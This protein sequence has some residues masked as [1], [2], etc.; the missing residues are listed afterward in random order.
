MLFQLEQAIAMLGDSGQQ[1]ATF[2]MCETLG[3]GRRLPLSV[4]SR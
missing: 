1:R 2:V 4:S 3:A